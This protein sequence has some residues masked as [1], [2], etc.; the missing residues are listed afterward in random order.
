METNTEILAKQL[1][2]H[3]C[4]TAVRG[5]REDADAAFQKAFQNAM[6]P[7]VK[8]LVAKKKKNVQE[9]FSAFLGAVGRSVAHGA[10]HQVAAGLGISPST[11]TSLGHALVKSSKSKPTTRTAAS[12]R[13]TAKKTKKTKRTTG[14]PRPR[15]QLNKMTVEPT[16][17]MQTKEQPK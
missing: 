5:P 7:R 8:R 6:R 16:D 14:K 1:I 2:R 15:R 10:A 12:K 11:V 13:P 9:D 3:C 17:L 4:E